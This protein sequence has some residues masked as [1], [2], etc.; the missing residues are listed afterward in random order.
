MTNFTFSY[1]ETRSFISYACP[2]CGKE[3]PLRS[4]AERHLKACEA[5]EAD[6]AERAAT[7]GETFEQLVRREARR[8]Q[9]ASQ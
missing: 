9:G 7:P 1:E 3:F 4:I 6:A 2:V 5:T 8:R